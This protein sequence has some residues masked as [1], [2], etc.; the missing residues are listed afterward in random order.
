MRRTAPSP[1]F[2]AQPAPHVA[3]VAL[4]DTPGVRR[5]AGFGLT[6]GSNG[7]VSSALVLVYAGTHRTTTTNTTGSGNLASV[8]LSSFSRVSSPFVNHAGQ[9]GSSRNQA[10]HDR[11][12]P[13]I[14]GGRY[15]DRL[16]RAVEL[17][18]EHPWMIMA[19]TV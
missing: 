16:R 18:G 5:L 3:G 2:T 8:V 19:A 14:L 9:I 17:A 4:T 13:G 6:A 1:L 10:R 7:R 11:L 15:E 12:R